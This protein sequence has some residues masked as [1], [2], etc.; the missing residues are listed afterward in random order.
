M[1]FKKPHLYGIQKASSLWY[2]KSLIFMAFKK[3]HLYGIQKASSLWYSKSLIFM[4]F[5]K[6]HLYGI[7]KASSPMYY[8]WSAFRRYLWD[9]R[10][11][12]G[13]SLTETSLCGA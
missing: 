8:M 13:P 6:P 1:V 12:C 7:Q 10:C 3:P 11:I 4:V 5:K 9:H 2:L